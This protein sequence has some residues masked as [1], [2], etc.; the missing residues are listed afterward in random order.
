MA[1]R[2]SIQKLAWSLMKKLS[3]RNLAK[4]FKRGKFFEEF[5]EQKRP[6]D[7][8]ELYRERK[9]LLLRKL[10][11]YQWDFK[12]RDLEKTTQRGSTWYYQLA[13]TKWMVLL[14]QMIDWMQHMRCVQDW[15]FRG[16]FLLENIWNIWNRYECGSFYWQDNNIGRDIC[17]RYK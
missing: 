14:L 12:C 15:T 6:K 8:R 17:I 3:R 10:Q 16:I 9:N 2:S 5:E 7:K 13:Q 1:C 4:V 11:F